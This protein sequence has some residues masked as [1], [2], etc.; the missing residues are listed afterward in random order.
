MAF[1]GIMNMYFPM[2][3]CD[4]KM[5]SEKNGTWNPVERHQA[6]VMALGETQDKLRSYVEKTP[7]LSRRV[8]KRYEKQLNTIGS[9]IQAAI[10]AT[11]MACSSHVFPDG[12]RP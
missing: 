4:P 1:Y 7:A 10:D 12:H 8:G 9:D 6:V 11:A 2:P 3:P 5:I